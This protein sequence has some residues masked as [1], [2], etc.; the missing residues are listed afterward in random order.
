MIEQI[1]ARPNSQ[2]FG[3]PYSDASGLTPAIPTKV[4]RAQA[5]RWLS[6]NAANRKLRSSKVTAYSADMK[7]GRWRGDDGIIKVNP[8]GELVNGQHRLTALVDSGLPYLW[9]LVQIAEGT[10]ESFRGDNGLVRTIRDATGHPTLLTGAATALLRTYYPRTYS[11]DEI[12]DASQAIEP[13]FSGL[14]TATLKGW[15]LSG[16]VGGVI[17]SVFRF[18]ISEDEI[19]EQYNGVAEQRHLFPTWPSVHSLRRQM[20]VVSHDGYSID[21]SMNHVLRASIAFNP[22]NRDITRIAIKDASVGLAAIRPMIAR[23]LGIA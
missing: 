5:V 8:R 13:T 17:L 20:A 19:I 2:A 11:R 12:I 3:E 6:N 14:T 23:M 16:L 21:R 9:L 7:A 22:A 4:T 18:P 10:A 15:S 1:L